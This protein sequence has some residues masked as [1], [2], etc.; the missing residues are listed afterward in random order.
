MTISPFRVVLDKHIPAAISLANFWFLFFSGCV[1][2]GGGLQEL[3]S[4]LNQK[5]TLERV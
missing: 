2:Q 1:E 5:R 4:A 3:R